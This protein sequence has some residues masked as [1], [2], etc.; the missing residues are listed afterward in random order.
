MIK[1]RLVQ[2]CESVAIADVTSSNTAVHDQGDYGPPREE[3]KI[4]G[5]NTRLAK[6]TNH[7]LP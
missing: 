5:E 7:V 2:L 1:Y 3:D 4:I 6:R